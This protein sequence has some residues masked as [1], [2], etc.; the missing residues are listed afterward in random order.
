MFNARDQARIVRAVKFVEQLQGEQEPGGAKAPTGGYATFLRIT[1][2][3]VAGPGGHTYFPGL[4]ESYNNATGNFAD[5]TRTPVWIRRVD[6]TDVTYA[7]AQRRVTVA[8]EARGLYLE[9]AAGGAGGCC[10]GTWECKP[11]KPLYM[12]CTEGLP[13]G[14]QDTYYARVTGLTGFCALFNDRYTLRV[15]FPTQPC[16]WI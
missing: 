5:I 7:K 4:V 16:V 15:Q 13:T 9:L 8:G 6:E 3:G 11:V 14:G 12:G 1:G 10:T 2:A